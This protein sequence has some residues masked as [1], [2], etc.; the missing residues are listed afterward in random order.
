MQV[1]EQ[2][3]AD[4]RR[5]LRGRRGCDC[6]DEEVDALAAVLSP[7][8]HYPAR[9]TVLKRRDRPKTAML[10]V[11]GMM[12]RHADARDGYRQILSIQLPGDF[13]DLQA[14][15]LGRYDHDVATLS[16]AVVV[17]VPHEQLAM[18][19]DRY[20]GFARRLWLATLF[21]G[22][23]HREWIFRIGRLQAIGRLAHLLCETEARLAAVGLSADGRFDF[24]L[25]QQ[26]IGETCGLTSVHVNRTVRRLREAALADVRDREVRILDRARLAALGE[27]TGDYLYLEA[28]SEAARA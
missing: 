6:P 14:F 23:M 19:A 9:R 20:P 4:A 2:N 12:C 16:D 1:G 21:D 7:R 13:V 28:A 22:A 26:D 27:F 5:F 11:S 8:I 15:Q 3:R 18:L 24:P 25:T 17:T 10:V